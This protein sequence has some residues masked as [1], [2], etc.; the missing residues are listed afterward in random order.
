MGHLARWFALLGVL[1]LVPAAT[2]LG[3]GVGEVLRRPEAGIEPLLAQEALVIGLVVGAT[4]LFSTAA[5]IRDSRRWA[6]MLGLAQS[7]VLI[8][9]GVGV[10]AVGGPVIRALGGSPELTLGTLPIGLAAALL[11]ARLFAE[12]WRASDIAL[13]VSRMDLRAIGALAGVTAMALLGHVL[14]AGV[15]S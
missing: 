9:A 3:A 13:P 14:A 15:A 7:A 5:G 8:V 1:A 6:L 2:L 4:F 11:G 12:L 10:L